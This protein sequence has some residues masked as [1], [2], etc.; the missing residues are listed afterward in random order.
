[1]PGVVERYLQVI[2]AHD[3]A[4]LG[5]CVTDDVVRVGPFGDT[6]RGRDEYVAWVAKLM[7]TLPGYSMDVRRVVYAGDIAFAELSE[8]VTVDGAPHVT[9]EVLVFDLADDRIAHIA[10]YLQRRPARD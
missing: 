2:R 7:P 1:M 8:T 9:P 4:G 3:W 10:I 5:E 6:Y